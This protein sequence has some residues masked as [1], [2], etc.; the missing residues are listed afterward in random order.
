MV[1]GASLARRLRNRIRRNAETQSS[2]QDAI[3]ARYALQQG[4]RELIYEPAVICNREGPEIDVYHF[5]DS[6]EYVADTFQQHSVPDQWTQPGELESTWIEPVYPIDYVAHPDCDPDFCSPDIPC[7]LCQEASYDSIKNRRYP[8]TSHLTP[9]SEDPKIILPE[10]L[11][12]YP[13]QVPQYS[14]EPES[15][16]LFLTPCALQFSDVHVDGVAAVPVPND[17]M[18][19]DL[20]ADVHD[21]DD[22]FRQ[23]CL[24]ADTE[25]LSKAICEPKSRR[26]FAPLKRALRGRLF[27]KFQKMFSIWKGRR[28]PCNRKDGYSKDAP[29]CC[30]KLALTVARHLT[31]STATHAT[32]R[33]IAY[34]VVEVFRHIHGGFAKKFLDCGAR[35]WSPGSPQ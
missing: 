9:R 12:F 11:S 25:F 19:T 31:P 21:D 30:D 26:R 24:L 20:E 17:K 14:A 16:S 3:L 13:E 15:E 4:T 22:P 34:H 28:C 10:L 1:Q 6:T 5:S 35:G 8:A 23:L 33:T 2:I 29:A 27:I 18:L 32:L 7:D